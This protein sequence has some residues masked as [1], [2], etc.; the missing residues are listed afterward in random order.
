MTL[1][2]SRGGQVYIRG[3]LGVFGGRSFRTP[4]IGAKVTRSTALTCANNTTIAVTWNS[5]VYDTANFFRTN[6]GVSLTIPQNGLYGFNFYLSMLEYNNN[7]LIETIIKHGGS[8]FI[9]SSMRFYDTADS[10]MQETVV[11]TG[12]ARCVAGELYDAQWGNYASTNTM[13]LRTGE[14]GCSFSIWKIAS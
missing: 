10:G 1:M 7:T 5:V 12:V 2:D 9:G 13:T 4:F 8:A 3:S 11:C 14:T 6:P